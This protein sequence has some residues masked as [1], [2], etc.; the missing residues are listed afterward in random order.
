ME[1]NA[2]KAKALVRVETFISSLGISR[3]T[4]WR[5]RKMKW[6]KTIVIANKHYISEEEYQL[7]LKRAASGEFER[8]RDLKA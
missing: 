7:F 8:V 2:S 4:F 6:I 3:T 5:W 1:S